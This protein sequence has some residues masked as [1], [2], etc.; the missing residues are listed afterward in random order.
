MPIPENDRSAVIGD[1]AIAVIAQGGMRGLTHRAVDSAAGLP[2]GS[3]SYYAR[4]RAALL[5]LVLQRMVRRDENDTRNLEEFDVERLAGRELSE[6]AATLADFLYAL[7]VD[8]RDRT[9]ARYECALEVTRRP[10]LRPIYDRAGARLRTPATALLRAMGATDPERHANLLVTYCEGVLFDR[11]VGFHRDTPL[12]RDA[13][14]GDLL[15][16][17]DGLLRHR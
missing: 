6:I 16:L 14:A 15:D 17:L 10:E 3:T 7:A 4:T 8:G 11:T 12:D 2:A 5:E 13:I 1:A 9:I